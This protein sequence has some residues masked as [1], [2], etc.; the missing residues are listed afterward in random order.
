MSNSLG[1]V[2]FFTIDMPATAAAQQVELESRSG[3]DGLAIWRTGSRGEPFEITTTIDLVGTLA[4][5]QTVLNAYRALQGGGPYT[6]TRA[7]TALG[8]VVVLSVKP[9]GDELVVNAIG[10]I[11]GGNVWLS[12]KWQLVAVA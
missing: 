1:P 7:G 11:N 12:A 8:S 6:L 4:T 9:A 10:G 5:A 3:V 2:V